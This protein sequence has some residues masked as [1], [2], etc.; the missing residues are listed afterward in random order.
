M[1]FKNSSQRDAT[2]KPFQKK[3]NIRNRDIEKQKI[4]PGHFRLHLQFAKKHIVL[5][6]HDEKTQF[7]IVAR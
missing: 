1:L 4:R 2:G 7:F 6:T 3:L 5:L